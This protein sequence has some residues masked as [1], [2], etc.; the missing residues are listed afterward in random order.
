M[1]SSV[2]QEAIPS[3]AHLH[4]GRPVTMHPRPRCLLAAG[5]CSCSGGGARHALAAIGAEAIRDLPATE[6]PPQRCV[7][8]PVTQRPHSWKPASQCRPCGA[9]RP[10]RRRRRRRR[11]RCCARWRRSTRAPLANPPTL[12]MS[13]RSG[14][15]LLCVRRSWAS[16]C[17]VECVDRRASFLSLEMRRYKEHL[18]CITCAAAPS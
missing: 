12:T 11:R 4:G 14:G 18:T 1:V 8:V 17:V 3:N 10:A 7:A 9:G 2:V 16:D 15:G 13:S 5:R 6:A